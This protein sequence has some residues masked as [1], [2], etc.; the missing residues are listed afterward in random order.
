MTGLAVSRVSRSV[1][2][3]TDRARAELGYAP[4]V[5]VEEGLEQ[6]SAAR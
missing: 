6:L 4:V 2:V 1:T 5:G 3:K